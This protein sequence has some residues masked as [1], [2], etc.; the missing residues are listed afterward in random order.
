MEDKKNTIETIDAVK[1]FFEQLPGLSYGNNVLQYFN[2]PDYGNGMAGYDNLKAELNAI[3]FSKSAEFLD[4]DKKV[5]RLKKEITELENKHTNLTSLLG[6]NTNGSEGSLANQI[7]T[8]LKNEIN[9]LIEKRNKLL[10]E[11]SEKEDLENERLAKQIEKENSQNNSF[12]EK[13]KA[14]EEEFKRKSDALKIQFEKEKTEIDNKLKSENESA[15][16][17]IDEAI[18]NAKLRVKLINQF[19]DFLEETNKNMS[20]YSNAIIG[21]LIAAIIGISFSIPDLLKIF[22]SYD[23]FVKNQ[24]DKITNLQLINHALG[25]LI[26]KLPWA[27]CLSAILTGMYSLLKGLL[28]TY[29]KINQDK[30]NMSAIYAISGNVANALN[31]YGIQLAEDITV[32]EESDTKEVIIKVSSK[33]LAQKKENIRWN[34]I[35]KYF[36]KMQQ[37]KEEVIQEEDPSK[38]K[39]V[40]DLL[41]KMIDKMPKN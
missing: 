31:E 32:D 38:L 33:D 27:L 30:R 13:T 12:I 37:S 19:R 2:L 8:S 24:G 41:N 16:K 18:S 23:D 5:K 9:Q 34:Q 21:I 25:L 10:N 40:N 36:E 3:D 6:E 20:L 22:S 1:L 29:E 39:I 4:L 11:I 7:L 35:M 26:V 15:N 28:T 14:L 17:K